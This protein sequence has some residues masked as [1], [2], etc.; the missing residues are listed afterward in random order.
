VHETPSDITFTVRVQ[1]RAKRNA[2]VGEIGGALKLALTAPPVDGRA[3]EACIEF[4]A[5][6]IGLPRSSI[7]I[8]SGHTRR[9]KVVRM[10]GLS[11]S[12]LRRR[13]VL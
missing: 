9:N 10:T 4:L 2:V 1:P 8:I 12:S 6:L 5:E 3:N 7:A 13:L 11:S